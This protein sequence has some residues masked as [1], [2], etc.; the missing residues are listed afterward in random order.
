MDYEE[1][2][3]RAGSKMPSST[4]SGERFEIPKVKGHIE[5]SKTIITNFLQLT[6]ILHREPEHLLKYLLKELATP[7]NLDGQRL[8]LGRKLSATLINDKIKRYSTEFVICKIC[9]KPDTNFVKEGRVLTL[10][11]TACGAKYPINSRI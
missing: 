6:S 8:I 3:D 10:K 5:G 2:L 11:C 9:G 1:L 7:G 4:T